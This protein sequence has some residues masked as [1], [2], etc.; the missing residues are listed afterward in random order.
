[1]E[2]EDTETEPQCRDHLPQCGFWKAAC[3]STNVETI[4]YLATNCPVTCK[5]GCAEPDDPP[6]TV[7]ECT[8]KRNEC[9]AW[10]DMGY[11]EDRNGNIPEFLQLYCTA[12]CTDCLTNECSDVRAE[13]GAWKE[14]GHCY[15]HAGVVHPFMV[16]YCASTCDACAGETSR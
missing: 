3:N 2:C 6:P 5:L 4:D 10:K 12:S 8:D 1:M 16:K 11:C 14:Q 9:E 7:V 15:N 13:C